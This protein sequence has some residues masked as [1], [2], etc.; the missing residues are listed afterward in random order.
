MKWWDRVEQTLVGL[1]GLCALAVGIWQVVGR[2]VA[3][4]ESIS[5]AEE[6]TVYLLVWAVMIVSSQLV[7]SNGHVRPDV[8]LHLLPTRVVRWVEMFNCVVAIVF[9][10]AVLWYGWAVVNVSYLLDE[11]SSTSLNFPMWIYYSAL[12]VGAAL[13]LLR[14]IMRLVGYA[15]FYDPARMSV[16][17]V[18]A[19]EVTPPF[20]PASE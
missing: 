18:P 17:P 7:R 15:F 11:R 2:Y 12:P 5:Y 10:A 19:H 16:R 20:S 9:L 13:M 1:L 6:V 3:P 14:Y 8:I 4:R